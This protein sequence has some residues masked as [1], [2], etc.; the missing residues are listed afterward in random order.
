MKI[1]EIKIN[2]KA[3]VSKPGA[4]NKKDTMPKYQRDNLLKFENIYPVKATPKQAIPSI[5]PIKVIVKAAQ[6]KPSVTSNNAGEYTNTKGTKAFAMPNRKAVLP[7]L[8]GLDPAI[9]A[10]A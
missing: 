7:V 5:A 3:I 6:V 9:P 8:K 1:G 2:P 4:I 10:A